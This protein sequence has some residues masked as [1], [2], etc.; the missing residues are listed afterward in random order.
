M[1]DPEDPWQDEIAMATPVPQIG[2]TH[3]QLRRQAIDTCPHCDTDGYRGTQ[4]CNH[5]PE[6]PAQTAARHIAQ[7]RAQMGWQ[8][9]TTKETP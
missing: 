4:V 1:R 9:P 7:I 2:P 6:N 5:Q 8:P 3:A